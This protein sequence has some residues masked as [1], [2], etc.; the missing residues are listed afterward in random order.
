MHRISLQ[1]D[2]SNSRLF[3]LRQQHPHRTAGSAPAVQRQPVNSVPNAAR[4]SPKK[5]PR[6]RGPASAVQLQPANS[7]PNADLP[8]LRMTAP[9]MPAGPAPAVLSTRA[10]SAQNAARRSLPVFP[11][12][13][14]TNAD[15]NR[16]RVQSRRSS[17]R[18]AAI[19]S[20]TAIFS[21]EA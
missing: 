15:G 1:W 10:S 2:S 17:V 20:M 9:W 12:T 6:M 16:K 4:R 8:S 5:S 18:N 14:A 7:A 21:K 11:S 13:S 19:R 3:R